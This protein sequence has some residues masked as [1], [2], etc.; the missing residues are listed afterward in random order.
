MAGVEQ[1]L[2]EWRR[3]LTRS[4]VLSEEDLDELE[5]HVRDTIEDLEPKGLS[6]DEALLVAVRRIGDPSLL[7]VEFEKVRPGLAWARRFYW[8]IAGVLTFG[9]LWQGAK[10]LIYSSA[11]GAWAVGLSA[12][13]GG[14]AAAVLALGGVA[15]VMIRSTGRP[16]GRLARGLQGAARWLSN[17]P[18]VCGVGILAATGADCLREK[19]VRGNRV[20]TCPGILPPEPADTGGSPLIPHPYDRPHAPIQKGPSSPAGPGEAAVARRSDRPCGRRHA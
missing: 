4:G 1:S 2:G 14:V 17:R 12:A 9:F 13:A 16:G 10:L 19:T 8:M 3:S 20:V 5:T 18:F 11:L 15:A 6:H 7:A